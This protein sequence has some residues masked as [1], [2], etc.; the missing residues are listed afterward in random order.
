LLE[1]AHRN[2]AF[3]IYHAHQLP[4]LEVLEAAIKPL[5]AGL[6]EVNATVFNSR[7]IPTHSDHDVKNRIERPNHIRLEGVDVVTGMQVI[8]SDFNV[9]KEQKYLPHQIEIP[10][11]DGMSAIKVR[12]IVKGDPKNANIVIDSPKGGLLKKSLNTK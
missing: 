12:W 10:T 7:I 6:F 1:D 5:G 3:T 9:T 8:N 2:A 11:I 4:K